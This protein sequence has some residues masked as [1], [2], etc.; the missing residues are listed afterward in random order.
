VEVRGPGQGGGVHLPLARGIVE[1]HGGVLQAH[2]LPGRQGVTYVV[3]LPLDPDAAP[4]FRPP[5]P[6]RENATTLLPELPAELSGSAGSAS[7]EPTGRQER[8]GQSQGGGQARTGH[9]R[10]GR[11]EQ[12]DGYAA[13]AAP[14]LPAARRAPEEDATAAPGA[15]DGMQGQAEGT[16]RSRR[17]NRLPEPE[18]IRPPRP[19][20]EP[21]QS[22]ADHPQGPDGSFPG[23]IGAPVYP[24]LEHALPPA[25]SAVVPERRSTGGRRRRLALG[26]AAG[27]ESSAPAPDHDLSSAA[28]QPAEPMA[29]A[30]LAPPAPMTPIS[31]S[32]PSAPAHAGTPDQQESGS[33]E[34]STRTNGRG[35][36]V[37]RSRHA[38][39]QPFHGAPDVPAAGSGNTGV[40]SLAQSPLQ[41]VQ[42]PP[43]GVP[44]PALVPAAREESAGPRRLLVWP[45]PEPATE[46]ALRARGFGP[47]LVSSREEV[48]AQAPTRPAALFVDPLTG[49][50]TR[51][52]LQ[53]LRTASGDAEVPMLVTAGLGLAAPE[54]VYGADPA[55]LLRALAP[56]DSERHAPR[57]LLVEQDQDIAGAFTASLER[58]GMQVEHTP[59]ENDAVSRASSVQPNLVVMDLMLI[60]RRRQG[61]IDWLRGSHRLYR[62]PLVVYTSVVD[63]REQRR[64]L[65]TGASML[66]F[67]E[68]STSPEVQA[69]IVDLLGKIAS[70]TEA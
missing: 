14:A 23:L 20:Q 5:A 8:E 58:R 41:A 53:T 50:I 45:E 15:V 19:Q 35:V 21:E 64:G 70:A 61:I 34:S 39:V 13:E 11:P 62:T 18:V 27:D 12:G 31:Q 26:P 43:Q 1:R 60:R 59:S 57:V 4:V 47:V 10:R 40:M 52:A 42:T 67:A 9:R 63:D 37:S 30:P 22:Q 25:G 29:P 16:D 69:R 24:G 2:E 56:R 49:P 36:Q 68:R 17:R 38:A 55:V 32:W 48:E 44:L 6:P 33:R 66:F 51:S 65:S 3:E 28:L 7:S 54:A 46:Q